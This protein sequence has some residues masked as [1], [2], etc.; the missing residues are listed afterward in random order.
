MTDDKWKKKQQQGSWS[1]QKSLPARIDAMIKIQFGSVFP[2]S[3][4]SPFMPVSY[5]TTKLVLNLANDRETDN[6]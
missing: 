1:V 6:P 4:T 5:Y 2:S 3:T